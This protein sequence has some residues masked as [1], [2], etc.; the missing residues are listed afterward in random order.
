MMFS[1][2]P[3]AANRTN[4][5]AHID[6][7]K[8]NFLQ[9]LNKLLQKADMHYQ[10][11]EHTALVNTACTLAWLAFLMDEFLVGLKMYSL[12]GEMLICG[13]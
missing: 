6:P 3:G 10:R 8:L 1:L 5:M 12:T 4:E 11:Q 7:F 2:K 13:K 9:E